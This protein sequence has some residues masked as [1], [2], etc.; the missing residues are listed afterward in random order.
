MNLKGKLVKVIPS[1]GIENQGTE[2]AIIELPPVDTSNLKKGDIV[3]FKGI[4]QETTNE[5]DGSVTIDTENGYCM[6]KGDVIAIIPS[7][8]KTEPVDWDRMRL[9]E[10]YHELVDLVKSLSS[11]LAELRA[12][13]EGIGK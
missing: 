13:V 11:Q 1:Y 12:K 3:I 5:D 7:A 10:Y 6:E 8:P 9:V 2:E 4:Y